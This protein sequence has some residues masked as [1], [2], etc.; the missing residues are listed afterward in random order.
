MPKQ[1]VYEVESKV[2]E[3]YTEVYNATYT[4]IAKGYDL[5]VK[6]LPIWRS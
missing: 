6:V 5:F 1:T 3:N 2:C 4:K